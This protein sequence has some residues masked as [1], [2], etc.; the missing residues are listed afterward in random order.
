MLRHYLV[1]LTSALLNVVKKKHRYGEAVD[2]GKVVLIYSQN[3]CA[4]WFTALPDLAK[5]F[6]S[7]LTGSTTRHRPL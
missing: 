7:L 5:G 6:L 2:S 1:L 4:L 3:L